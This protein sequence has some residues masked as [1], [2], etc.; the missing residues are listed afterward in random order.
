MILHK[1]NCL[2]KFAKIGLNYEFSALFQ[3]CTLQNFKCVVCCDTIMSNVCI[4]IICLL[5]AIEKKSAVLKVLLLQLWIFELQEN[6]ICFSL[7]LC[8]KLLLRVYL[9]LMQYKNLE[10]VPKHVPLKQSHN[11]LYGYDYFQGIVWTPVLY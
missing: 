9:A 4:G 1:Q 11:N 6:A 7:V 10:K 3:V 8:K 5:N 2:L